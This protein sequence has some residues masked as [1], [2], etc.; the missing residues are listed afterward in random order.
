MKRFVSQALLMGAHPEVKDIV[1]FSK[2]QWYNITNGLSPIPTTRY[3]VIADYIG[4]DTLTHALVE[5]YKDY[6]GGYI[7]G[8]NSR[9]NHLRAEATNQSAL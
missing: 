6:I 1:K 4:R 9:G 2:Q 7:N 3:R 8:N 5:D